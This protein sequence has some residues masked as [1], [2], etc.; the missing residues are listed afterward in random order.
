MSQAP[1]EL[2]EEEEYLMV[3]LRT[4]PPC[5][6]IRRD[7]LADKLAVY[8]KQPGAV[9]DGRTPEEVVASLIEREYVRVRLPGHR[10]EYCMPTI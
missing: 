4:S 5:A 3:F 8:R 2:S 7:D 10:Q 6:V 1:I 9:L